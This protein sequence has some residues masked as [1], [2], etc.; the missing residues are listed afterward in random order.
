MV[1]TKRIEFD[2]TRQHHLLAVLGEYRVSGDF[3]CVLFV[4]AG[5]K[6]QRLGHSKRGTAQA[7]TLW[8]LTQA[9]LLFDLAVCL[10]LSSLVLFVIEIE[11]G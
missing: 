2:V 6:I 4:T 10:A 9:L 11:S 7:F 1:L 5:E 3:L 8:V